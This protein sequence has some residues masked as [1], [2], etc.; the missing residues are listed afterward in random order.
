[1]TKIAEQRK[2]NHLLSGESKTSKASDY[3]KVFQI[4]SGIWRN[5]RKI[6]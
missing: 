1:M 6:E 5:R 3:Q 2:T 4:K